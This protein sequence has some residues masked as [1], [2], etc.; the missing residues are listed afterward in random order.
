MNA[1][2]ARFAAGILLAAVAAVLPAAPS[3]AEWWRQAAPIPGGANEVIGASLGGYL[4]VYGGQGPRSEALGV[5]WRFDPAGNTWERLQPNPVPV[6][7]GAMVGVGDK[8]YLFG[9]FRLP[10]NGRVGW[11][12][13][14]RTWAYDTKSAT[15]SELPPMPTPRGALA[16]TA[17]GTKVYVIGGAGIPRGMDLPDGLVGGGPSEMLGTVEVFD[18]EAATWSTRQPMPTPRNH[19]GLAHVSGT[20]YAVGGRV[21]SCYSNGFSSNVWVNEAY[22]IATD[23]WAMRAPMPTARSGI[24]VEVVGGVV[25]V[26]GGEGWVEDF[27]GVFRTHEAYDPGTD[28]WTKRVRMPTPRHGFA[29]GMIDGRIHAVSGVNNAG[30]A[31]TLSVVEVNEVWEP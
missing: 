19:H 21:G 5:F 15:W 28:R 8:L 3:H 1:I 31:G 2:V 30:G 7:H 14:R 4:Y 16:A 24:G 22:D 17:A 29:T 27:G 18:T 23:T 25:H 10:E 20:I 9:G 13:E 11:V 12:P 26:M 6:H